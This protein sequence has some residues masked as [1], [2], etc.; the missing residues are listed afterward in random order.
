[1]VPVHPVFHV[2]ILKKCIGD[3]VSIIPLEGLGVDENLT[4]EEVAVEVLDR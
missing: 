4:Y 1:M 3:S 2:S